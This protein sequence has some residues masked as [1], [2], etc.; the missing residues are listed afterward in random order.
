[1]MC[2]SRCTCCNCHNREARAT[3][4]VVIETP[5]SC[6]NNEQERPVKR[7]RCNRSAC[8]TGKCVCYAAGMH[9]TELCKCVNCLNDFLAMRDET[10]IERDLVDA[11]Q[12]FWQDQQDEENLMR[13]IERSMQGDSG[14]LSLSARKNRQGLDQGNKGLESL[15]NQEIRLGPSPI[16]AW[17]VNKRPGPREQEGE[18]FYERAAEAPSQNA[19]RQPVGYLCERE[20][21]VGNTIRVYRHR[22]SVEDRLKQLFMP[23]Q[24]LGGRESET[25][26]ASNEVT[27]VD[28]GSGSD[29]KQDLERLPY[30]LPPTGQYLMCET[31]GN[32]V[33]TS[34]LVQPETNLE[35]L[36]WLPGEVVEWAAEETDSGNGE[37]DE[38]WYN[39]WFM[40]DSH[41]G[42]QESDTQDEIPTTIPVLSETNHERPV[43]LPE[44]LEI[45]KNDIKEI[46]VDG[47][48]RKTDE[49]MWESER[50]E[51]EMEAIIDKCV[52]ECVEIKAATERAERMKMRA[53][54]GKI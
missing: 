53:N 22:V 31:A 17:P 54:K 19:L 48:G 43:W 47:E 38:A 24:H 34:T 50:F 21:T 45:A 9:C 32:E 27:S 42:Q 23:D 10:L 15:T 4:P 28:L 52:Q 49:E 30:L 16:S 6:G 46:G 7:C 14:T 26:D 29:L 36:G 44:E 12:Q 25:L 40:P 13:T 2:S 39:Q 20:R 1:M 37:Q 8:H 33:P 18:G 5:D 35:M 41:P 11:D 3:F 51:Q